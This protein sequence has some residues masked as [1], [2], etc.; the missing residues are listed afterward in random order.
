MY[1]NSGFKLGPCFNCS[2]EH[3]VAQCPHPKPPPKLNTQ[4]RGVNYIGSNP[5]S[6]VQEVCQEVDDDDEGDFPP[7]EE[8][9]GAIGL[10]SMG[11]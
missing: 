6:S 1:N 7:V 5:G 11:N 4:K 2:G 9:V 3:R 10:A 8:S